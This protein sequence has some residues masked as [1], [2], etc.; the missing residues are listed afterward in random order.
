MLGLPG[1]SQGYAPGEAV[2]PAV[3]NVDFQA[4]KAVPELEL[5]FSENDIALPQICP[6]RP[7]PVIPVNGVNQVISLVD[8]LAEFQDGEDTE[9]SLDEILADAELGRHVVKS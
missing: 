5:G 1:R 7:A 6:D 3:I 8:L 2:F 4:L 9:H